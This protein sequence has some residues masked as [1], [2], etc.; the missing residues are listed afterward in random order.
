M[1]SDAAAAGALMVL[2]A[3]LCAVPVA[4]IALRQRGLGMRV[5][6]PHGVLSALSLASSAC[7][8]GIGVG[9][10]TLDVYTLVVFGFLAYVLLTAFFAVFQHH[11][12]QL[13]VQAS[14]SLDRGARDAM[15][16]LNNWLSVAWVAAAAA[17]S[18][19]WIVT[20]FIYNEERWNA[21]VS[22]ASG[23]IGFASQ[24][25]SLVLCRRLRNAVMRHQ[26]EIRGTA[27][28]EAV[29]AFNGVVWR[30][31]ALSVIST[32]I[33]GSWL[34]ALAFQAAQQWSSRE[35]VEDS[36]AIFT[37]PFNMLAALLAWKMRRNL[38]GRVSVVVTTSIVPSSPAAA[39]SGSPR[40]HNLRSLSVAATAA[41]NGIARVST[42]SR[43]L[44]LPSV[45]T[46]ALSACEPG[47]QA[48]PSI[49]A[50]AVE[51]LASQGE[52]SVSR[53]PEP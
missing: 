11:L 30:L 52:G 7:L 23:A 17:L 34:A 42:E 14:P 8:A 35:P 16:R 37:V 31:R 28:A 2:A 38:D 24:V 39:S 5:H 15:I 53:A 6:A 51:A 19:L 43:S 4:T 48:L 41:S 27:T 50:L 9:A 12:Y 22:L 18:V 20:Y 44:A 21:W 49:A 32:V 45:A 33:T 13:A 10:V 26:R 40:F 36:T 47:S 1:A 46:G 29:A 3:L 25:R